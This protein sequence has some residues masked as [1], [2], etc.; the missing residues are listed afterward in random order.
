MFQQVVIFLALLPDLRR[1]AVEALRTLFRT[2]EAQVGNR[3]RDAPVAVVKRMN[4]HEPQMRDA[5][6]EDRI[7]LRPVIEP[8][9]KAR[10]FL[11]KTRRFWCLEMNPFF[12]DRTR[13]DL[14]RAVAVIAPP[15]DRYAP[16]A[17]TPRRE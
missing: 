6:L 2:G 11:F 12:A 14:H 8:V 10:H 9:Q 17:A 13:D 3:A 4:C 15:A 1:H 16:H 5:G 7:D